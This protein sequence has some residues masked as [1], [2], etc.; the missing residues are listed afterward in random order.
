[1]DNNVVQAISVACAN[2]GILTLS[3]NFR[4]VG[5][6]G[7]KHGGGTDEQDDLEACLAFVAN[8][9]DMAGKLLGVAG[10]SFGGMVALR[11]AIRS[12]LVA[13]LALVSPASPWSELANLPVLS[14]PWLFISGGLDEFIPKQFAYQLK[15]KAGQRGS[16]VVDQSADHFWWG[17]ENTLANQVRMFV[18]EHLVNCAIQDSVTF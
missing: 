5:N 6:S 15:E 3:F 9:P 4:G 16:V 18:R 2:D 12:Q 13:A 14:K 11:L 7:G 10:Y 17:A 8:Q 1:M